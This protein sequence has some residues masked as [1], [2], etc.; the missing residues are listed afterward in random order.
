ML[1]VV[2]IDDEEPSLDKLEKLLTES[3]EVSVA[4]R[5]TEP[6]AALEFLRY[7][8]V[9]AAFL[10]IEMPEIDGIELADRIID[11]H[12]GIDTI[13][14]TAYNQYAVEAFRLNAIDYLMKPVTAARLA[15]TLGRL[16]AR[17]RN[18]EAV[19]G[20]KAECFG[21]FKVT[22]PFGEVKFRTEKAEELLAFLIDRRG[23]Y[24][25]RSEIIDHIW[26]D[27]DG[28]R[29]IIHFNTTLHYIK[30]ALY[31]HGIKLNIRFDRGS[32]QLELKELDCDYLLFSSYLDRV[33]PMNRDTIEEYVKIAGLYQGDYLSGWEND[34]VAV[35]RL[36]LKEQYIGLLL[37]LAEYDKAEGNP[38]RAAIWLKEGIVREP[39]HRELNYRLVELLLSEE[40]LVMA[41][42]Y[43]K[44]YQDGIR[45]KLLKEPD[46]AFRRLMK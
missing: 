38:C 27:F 5:F 1:K 43:F 16:T 26:E 41:E 17:R 14:V 11:L 45:K 10:D 8:R 20:M 12:Y 33:A 31:D 13:F 6:L 25:S 29:A 18:P 37:E 28:D 34:W 3:G 30:K 42:N 39:L 22:S 9:D 44:L 4:G 24:V 46:E 35:K 32:Y 19:S 36:L 15:E 7:S 2:I 23:S 21:R 40:E